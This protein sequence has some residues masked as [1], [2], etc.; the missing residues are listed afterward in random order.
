MDG[1]VKPHRHTDTDGT[2]TVKTNITIQEE[3][4]V[5]TARC[6]RAPFAHQGG[7]YFLP[8]PTTP[9]GREI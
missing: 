1:F 9:S 7:E 5:A 3:A 6:A 8:A 2:V 4:S